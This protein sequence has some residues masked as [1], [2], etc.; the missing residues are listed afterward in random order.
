MVKH[1]VLE[2]AL[3][4]D[5]LTCVAKHKYIKF[6]YIEKRKILLI[7]DNVD[8]AQQ[9][10]EHLELCDYSVRSC[11]NT[12]DFKRQLDEFQPE[13]VLIDRHLVGEDG[14]DLISFV[15]AHSKYGT[16]GVVVMTGDAQ[17]G[18]KLKG[19]ES[20]ADVVLTKPFSWRELDLRLQA[21]LRR[22]RSYASEA[23]VIS[24]HDVTVRPREKRVLISGLEI[25]L[26]RVQYLLLLEFLSRRGQVVSREYLCSKVL[27]LQH[28][29]HRTVDVHINSLRKKLGGSSK[30]IKTVRGQGYMCA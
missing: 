19:F 27:T 14:Y 6:M 18:N 13:I 12:T 2:M 20:G 1:L 29:N 23:E 11:S 15:R 28:N 24:F 17:L 8:L 4:S 22:S 16:I 9:L 5:P 7:D 21:L 3:R 26:P 10:R 30:M 25:S